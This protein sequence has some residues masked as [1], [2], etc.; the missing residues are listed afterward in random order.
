MLKLGDKPKRDHA[1]HFWGWIER[2]N[3]QNLV[4]KCSNVDDIIEKGCMMWMSFA[5]DG[6]RQERKQLV[7]EH[8]TLKW[9]VPF[10]KI[11]LM[12]SHGKWDDYDIAFPIT[13]TIKHGRLKYIECMNKRM[14]CM[15]SPPTVQ[16]FDIWPILILN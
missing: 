6:N 5:M 9:I 16:I 3:A 2:P 4:W 8:K 10:L 12:S 7:V 13:M 14:N 15:M 1:T 11:T